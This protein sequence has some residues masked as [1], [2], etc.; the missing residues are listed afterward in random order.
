VKFNTLVDKP[1]ATVIL[2]SGFATQDPFHKLRPRLK[3]NIDDINIMTASWSNDVRSIVKTYPE[4]KLIIIG[5]SF[6]GDKA[7]NM[8]HN[9]DKV[10]QKCH[11][12][13]VDPVRIGIVDQYLCDH[14]KAP[15]NTITRKCY[16]RD[17]NFRVLFRSYVISN[18]ENK[19]LD[20]D[21]EAKIYNEDLLDAIVED[22][23]GIVN[24]KNN[25]DYGTQAEQVE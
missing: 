1:K 23:R 16:I 25:S 21:H 14:R 7:M 8:A 18:G 19:I 3:Y 6:G 5:Y 17:D 2:V 4:Q 24:G 22:V 10:N 9:F 13:L 11:L 15:K 20:F 12:I